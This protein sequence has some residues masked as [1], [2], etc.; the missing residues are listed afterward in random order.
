[1]CLKF[2]LASHCV[3]IVAACIHSWNVDVIL[4]ILID[5]T[6][7]CVAVSLVAWCLRVH[8]FRCHLWARSLDL[9]HSHDRSLDRSRDLSLDLACLFLSRR[10]SDSSLAR[11]VGLSGLTSRRLSRLFATSSGLCRD[12]IWFWCASTGSH[13]ILTLWHLILAQKSN[14]SPISL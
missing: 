2:L 7:C 13:L 12:P 9:S 5:G 4:S 1:M 8:D 11:F 14:R 3:V 10:S 6:C